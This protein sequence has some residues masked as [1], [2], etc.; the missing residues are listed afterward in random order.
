MKKYNVIGS[1]I[2]IVSM[3]G[4]AALIVNE[5]GKIFD[6]REYV[7]YKEGFADGAV[8]GANCEYPEYYIQGYEA[9]R[10]SECTQEH[11]EN[12]IDIYR[13]GWNEGY[14]KGKEATL[15]YE[16]YEDNW[17][18]DCGIGENSWYDGYREG[19]IDG[20]QCG[21]N[22]GAGIIDLGEPGPTCV[23]EDCNLTNKKTL[24]E[25]LHSNGMKGIS[26]V[27]R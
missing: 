11:Y 27:W 17:C 7:A 1:L 2:I 26:D 15:R 16:G 18:I 19:Y 24:L 8:Y 25:E 6:E 3:L 22:C 10:L 23:Y 20:W 4:A 12:L 5:A 21:Y 14:V 13:D 9:G